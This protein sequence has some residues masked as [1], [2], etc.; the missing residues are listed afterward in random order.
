MAIAK[1]EI[2]KYIFDPKNP[3]QCKSYK[4]LLRI[5]KRENVA[6]FSPEFLQH[7]LGRTLLD[8]SFK[9]DLWDIPDN[10]DGLS[11]SQ[12]VDLYI[13][14]LS[15]KDLEEYQE[16]LSDSEV[17]WSN[18]SKYTFLKSFVKIDN[19]RPE[20]STLEYIDREDFK[21][22][23]KEILFLNDSQLSMRYFKKSYQEHFIFF[24]QNYFSIL[25]NRIQKSS[26]FITI[27][28]N[29]DTFLEYENEN[30]KPIFLKK[31]EDVEI[32]LNV[33]QKDIQQEK[34]ASNVKEEI[35]TIDSIK[36]ENFF[37]IECIRLEHLKNK[38]EIYIVGEN[39]D[40]KT[41]LL[42]SIAIGLAGV[43]EGDVFNLVK[44]Q[45][46]SSIEVVDNSGRVHT[47]NEAIYEYILAYG[48]SR[49]NSCQMKE[50]KTGYLTLFENR[51]DLR[52]PV[53][54]LQYL[55]HNEKSGKTNI[56]SVEEA[57]RLL[58]ML[59][60]KE[61]EIEITPDDVLFKERGSIVSFEQ[62]SAGYKGVI[63]II[64]DLIAR[65]YEKQSYVEDI[66]DFQGVVLID[67][68]E[69]HLHPKWKYNFMKKL[70]DTF[71]LVQ[72]IVTTHSPT[73]ILGAS[74]EAVFYKIYKDDGKVSI[75]HQIANE[76]YTNNSLVS[77]PLFDMETITSREYEKA[78][79]S[80]D[81]I[82]EKIHQQVA[83]KIAE[84]INVDEETLLKL[85]DEELEKI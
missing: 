30:V 39:G 23:S 62:L 10:Y 6:F 4:L 53:E 3:K 16:S 18:I 49:Y 14:Q 68:V 28:E 64:C 1:D 80:D 55:D 31:I 25:N 38:K 79:S 69:L 47:Q 78:V 67:E 33:L 36:V 22:Y 7:F 50:D 34:Y 63:T 21:K 5:A 56:V 60:N 52:S 76:G 74:K 54:W 75:S 29:I 65:L 2:E 70:R 27:E 45:E 48:A 59:L 72:F 84:D 35:A 57:K 40:G 58:N 20:R 24:S 71:P 73:V 81:Y 17:P 41:L 26:I 37:S 8:G 9:D 66:K 15:K 43:N 85:I 46:T 83:K 61:V 32:L 82:Y 13:E 77:S 11:F 19:V 44:S 51:Y 12:K 42:Q